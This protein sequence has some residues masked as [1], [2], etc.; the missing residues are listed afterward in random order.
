MRKLPPLHA[1]RAFE[2]AARH[3]HFSRAADELHLTPTAIS[4][5]VRLLEEILG[6]KLFHRYPRPIRL[7]ESGARLF[8]VLR[9]ALDRI[10]LEISGLA[11]SSEQGPLRLSVT[12]AF[13]SRWL[14]PRLARLSQETG[15]SIAV[16]ADDGPADLRQSEIDMA[17]RYAEKPV[18]DIEWHRLFSDQIIPVAAP[19]AF[20][21]AQTRAPDQVLKMPLLSY[22]WKVGADMA[23]GWSHWQNLAGI[24]TAAPKISQSFSEEIHAIDAAVA[25]HGVAL[26]SR[27]LVADL[28]REG[29]LVQ[30]S[31]IELP[32]RSFWAVFLSGHPARDRLTILLEWIRQQA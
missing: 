4:H 26:V 29:K 15:L 16:E 20:G 30:L 28:L 19:G 7:T 21:E 24:A 12:V 14:M 9:D 10:A 17:I 6:T 18:G 22:R 27:V 3:L 5:Q 11:V 31:D 25:G 23:P 8:P 2:A 1:L 13:A 32:G